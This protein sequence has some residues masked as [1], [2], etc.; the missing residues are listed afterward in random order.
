FCNENICLVMRASQHQLVTVT[1]AVATLRRIW[2]ADVAAGPLSVFSREYH[3][4]ASTPAGR[5][6]DDEDFDDSAWFT[7]ATA[8]IPSFEAQLAFDVAA[9]Q[10]IPTAPPPVRPPAVAY[11]PIAPAKTASPSPSQALVQLPPASVLLPATRRGG[12]RHRATNSGGG[13]ASSRPP[14]GFAFHDFD[15]SRRAG[16]RNSAPSLRREHH[17]RASVNS[18]AAKGLQDATTTAGAA[19]IALVKQ[20]PVPGGGS[21][22]G[23]DDEEAVVVGDTVRLMKLMLAEIKVSDGGGDVAVGSQTPDSP[24]QALA[25]VPTAAEGLPPTSPLFFQGLAPFSGWKTCAPSSGEAEVLPASAR[26]SALDAQP[27]L[28]WDA[29]NVGLH[30]G[31]SGLEP[32]ALLFI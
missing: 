21:G 14:R 1:S 16:R 32:E 5:D 7:D 8:A 30:L 11:K 4:R 20:A 22:A 3:R 9:T 13:N 26:A 2:D 15:P 23:R 18:C 25:P 24:V 6:D 17:R 10:H 12:A 31:Y 27:L 29:I 19:T 28:P